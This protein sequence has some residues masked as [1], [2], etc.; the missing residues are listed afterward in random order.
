MQTNSL[1]YVTLY[2]LP[3]ILSEY[4][5]FLMAS[6]E[7]DLVELDNSLIYR[8]KLPYLRNIHIRASSR[9]ST[10]CIEFTC[11]LKIDKRNKNFAFKDIMCGYARIYRFP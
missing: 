1:V 2:F 3:Q 7:K 8:A 9:V 11:K 10:Y 6:P 5:Y 4:R